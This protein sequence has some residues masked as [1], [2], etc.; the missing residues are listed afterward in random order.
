MAMDIADGTSPTTCRSNQEHA[1]PATKHLWTPEA[2]ARLR[3]YL[4]TS[5]I[6]GGLGTRHA[7]QEI[8][9][10][11]HD[12]PAQVA[13]DTDAIAWD[14]WQDNAWTERVHAA[15]ATEVI[16]SKLDNWRAR[17]AAET[18]D[19][20]YLRVESPLNVLGRGNTRGAEIVLN[21]TMQNLGERLGPTLR[22][23]QRALVEAG[24]VLAEI[25]RCRIGLRCGVCAPCFPE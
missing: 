6:P 13:Q 20:A 10:T 7:G 8:L 11:E 16:A 15:T 2:E 12:A 23:R 22:D 1:M 3:T 14:V 9:M 17:P 24:H 19:E 18:P 21:R 25:G 4:A 5:Y